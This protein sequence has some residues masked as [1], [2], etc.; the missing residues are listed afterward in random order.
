MKPLVVS[1]CLLKVAVPARITLL[2]NL[3]FVPTLQL[4]MQPSGQ[5]GTLFFWYARSTNYTYCIPKCLLGLWRI[6]IC[7]TTY[8]VLRARSTQIQVYKFAWQSMWT[9]GKSAGTTA[10]LPICES[11]SCTCWPDED[12]TV[13]TSYKAD[14]WQERF[15]HVQDPAWVHPGFYLQITNV[16]ARAVL[17]LD[18]VCLLHWF[19]RIKRVFW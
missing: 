13:D 14:I 11:W 7:A 15:A 6:K 17:G 19:S 3:K 16:W 5:P 8:C 18:E 2:P 10:W 9:P 4:P 1:P 12:W